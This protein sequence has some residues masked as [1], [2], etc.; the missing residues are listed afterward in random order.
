MKYCCTS[1]EALYKNTLKESTYIFIEK[2]KPHPRSIF[3]EKSLDFYLGKSIEDRIRIYYCPKC[4]KKLS[5]FYNIK[6]FQS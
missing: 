6:Y 1:F 5:T 4:G 3:Q 2:Y